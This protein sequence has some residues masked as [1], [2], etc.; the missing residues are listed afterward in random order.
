M[1]KY[2]VTL[3]DETTLHE[4]MTVMANNSLSLY[5]DAGSIFAQGKD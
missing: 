5:M 3:V 4:E 1:R 2:T